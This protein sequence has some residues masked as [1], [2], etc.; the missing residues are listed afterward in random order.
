MKIFED[1]EIGGI[2]F[3]L[4][5]SVLA[6]ASIIKFGYLAW[7]RPANFLDMVRKEKARR[8]SYL[9]FGKDEEMSLWIMRVL[10]LLGFFTIC[11]VVYV[12]FLAK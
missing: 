1:P 12:M 11:F 2:I 8:Q 6:T 5:V 4:V 9:S 3:S 7:F 10:T